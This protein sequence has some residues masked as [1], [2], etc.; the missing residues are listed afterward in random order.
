VANR[1]ARGKIREVPVKRMVTTIFFVCFLFLP[2]FCSYGGE[3]IVLYHVGEKD[4]VA[5]TLLRKHLASKGYTVSAFDGTDNIEKQIEL[6]NK[7]NKL[8]AA[9]FLAVEFGF[10][11]EENITIAV[12]DAKKK[13]GQ[14]LTIE[15]VPGTHG[16]GSKRFA[17]LVA[18]SFNRK[19][20]ELPLFPLLGVDM[21]GTFMAIVCQ[22][23]RVNEVLGKVADSMQKY[24]GKGARK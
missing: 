18:E 16:A 17:A 11:E 14:M 5:S 19:V 22:K 12:T 6:A 3:H 21:P 9:L 13:T 24:F 4:P 23:E 10:G 20:L 7:I 15:D 2:F 1:L 8:K